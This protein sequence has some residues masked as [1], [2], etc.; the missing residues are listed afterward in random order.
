MV[1]L[2]PTLYARHLQLPFDFAE[3]K[4]YAAHHP[5]AGTSVFRA[6]S[7]IVVLPIGYALETRSRVGPIAQ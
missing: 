7:L 1:A 3:E 5:A 6:A 4:N 2:Y